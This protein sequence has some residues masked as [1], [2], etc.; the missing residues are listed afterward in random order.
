[1]ADKLQQVFA[2]V[3]YVVIFFL[4]FLTAAVWFNPNG[5]PADFATVLTAV[6]ALAMV[7]LG[8]L[9][10]RFSLMRRQKESERLALLQHENI[11]PVLQ[12]AADAP[13]LIDIAIQPRKGSGLCR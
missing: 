5:Y 13:H 8:Y 4:G 9:F 3:L 2:P 12:P 11:R 6:A 10:C 7:F 1:M